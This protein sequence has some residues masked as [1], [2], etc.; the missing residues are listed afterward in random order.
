M[1]AW[2]VCS[3]AFRT[4]RIVSSAWSS[5]SVWS[6]AR[7]VSEK[8]TLLY[9]AG[10]GA[11][12]YT[13]KSSQPLRYCPPAARMHCESCATGMSALQTMAMSRVTAGKRG[14]GV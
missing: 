8:A 5:V 12:V 11:P 2:N 13:S 1:V 4:L 6:S 14:S 3:S 9:P 7:S 10:I